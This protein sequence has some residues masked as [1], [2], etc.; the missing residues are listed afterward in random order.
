[1]N[2][3]KRREF[4]LKRLLDN[5]IFPDCEIYIIRKFLLNEGICVMLGLDTNNE[6]Q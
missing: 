6:I 4:W 2:K 1:M 3:Y 5:I